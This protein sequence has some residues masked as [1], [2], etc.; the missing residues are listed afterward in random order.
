MISSLIEM[1][2]T[3]LALKEYERCRDVL[4]R[5][6]DAKPSR[7]TQALYEELRGRSPCK[8]G[9]LVPQEGPMVTSVAGRPSV[10]ILPFAN[11]TGNP[12]RDYMV[13]GI[14]ED[15]TMGV[16]KTPWLLVIGSNQLYIFARRDRFVGAT[17]GACYLVQGSFRELG[18]QIRVSA[19]LV[20][21]SSNVRLWSDHFTSRRL[22]LFALQ[23]ELVGRIVSSLISYPS[24]E[25]RLAE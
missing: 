5:D 4:R 1:G 20:D 8:L 24:G 15:V 22:D 13:D 18:E 25:G 12:Q 23:D 17:L 7:Q 21:G 6:F 11:L 14:V 2:E 10:A 3:A 16:A 19:T 9:P